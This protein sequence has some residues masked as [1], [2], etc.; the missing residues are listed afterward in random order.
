[1]KKKIIASLIVVIGIAIGGYMVADQKIVEVTN[2]ESGFMISYDNYQ[3][4]LANSDLVVVAQLADDPVSVETTLNGLSDG[5]HLSKIKISKIIKG[6]IKGE[7]NKKVIEIRE[8][9]FIREKGAM[10]GKEEV[11]YGDYT[12]MEKGKKYLL[13]LGWGEAWGQ[14]GISSSQ[15]GKFNLDGKDKNELKKYQ[16]N[17]KL[18]KLKNDIFK[19]KEMLELKE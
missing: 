8:P 7:I 5:Y 4:R 12:K 3:D 1:M 16:E 17:D 14:Y 6:E 15:E 11:Y 2:I 13:F 19:N 9:Y 18:L 10:P